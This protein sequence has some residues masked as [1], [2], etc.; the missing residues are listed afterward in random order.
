MHEQIIAAM[1]RA[2]KPALKSTKRAE[3]ILEEFW[4]GKMALVWD[5]G[6]VHAAANEREVALTNQQASTPLTA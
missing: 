5:T 4:T 1:V 6:D 2:L 3:Q